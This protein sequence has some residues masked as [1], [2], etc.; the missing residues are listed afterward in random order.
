ML[1]VIRTEPLTGSEER[2]TAEWEF[3]GLFLRAR[4]IFYVF[5]VTLSNVK[6]QTSQ[7]RMFRIWEMKEDEYTKSPRQESG[8]IRMRDIRKKV[9]T[10]F[11]RLCM[12]PPC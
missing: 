7:Y 2:F 11:V 9:L 10:K 6:M 12:E 5:T 1:N 4:P 8:V 3:V